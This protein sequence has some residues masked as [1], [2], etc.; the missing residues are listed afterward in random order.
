M[1]AILLLPVESAIVNAT[2]A[3]LPVQVPSEYVPTFVEMPSPG[4]SLV[5]N[6]IVI[7]VI[8]LLLAVTVILFFLY[9]RTAVPPV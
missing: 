7:A 1:D 2:E 6:P 8:V 3:A 4:V 9:I 5:P